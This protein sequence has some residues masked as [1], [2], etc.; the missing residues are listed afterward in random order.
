[1]TFVI[2]QIKESEKYSVIRQR[3]GTLTIMK[4]DKAHQIRQKKSNNDFGIRYCMNKRKDALFMRKKT[5]N[6]KR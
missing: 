3:K 6:N 1:M 5:M 2:K 4:K